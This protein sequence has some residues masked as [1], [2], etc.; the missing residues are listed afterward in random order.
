MFEEKLYG[1]VLFSG[2]WVYESFM[3]TLAKIG[4]RLARGKL[5]RPQTIDKV[6]G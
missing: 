5:N 3:G 4:I 2:L 1:D 6:K